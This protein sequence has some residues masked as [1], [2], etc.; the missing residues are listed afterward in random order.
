MTHESTGLPAVETHAVDV[1]GEVRR[2][3]GA[4]VEGQVLARADTRPR[5]IALNPRAPV[6]GRWIDPGLGEHPIAGARV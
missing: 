1:D 2:W 3:V 5:G 6:P 4:N